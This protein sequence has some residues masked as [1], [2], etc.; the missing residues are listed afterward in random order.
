[1]TDMDMKEV[2]GLNLVTIQNWKASTTSGKLFAN[3]AEGEVPSPPVDE[4]AMRGIR[5][6]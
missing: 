3:H 5:R 6:L 1:M 2:A 4:T